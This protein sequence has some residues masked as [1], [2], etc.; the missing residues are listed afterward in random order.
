M[1][2]NRVLTAVSGV[3]AVAGVLASLPV[4]ANAAAYYTYYPTAVSINGSVLS[5]PGH[6][7]EKDPFGGAKAAVTSF[8]PIW[9]IDEALGKLNVKVSWDGVNGVLNFTTPSGMT[10]NYPSTPKAVAINSGTMEIQIN[11]KVV[12][13][14]PRISY[15]DS[16]TV[17]LTTF[18]PVYYLEKALGYMGVTTG[19]NGT[20]WTMQY[21]STTVTPPTNTGE[22]VKAAAAVAF[23]KAMGI[24]PDASSP[25]PY[26]DVSQ[27]DWEWIAPLVNSNYVYVVKGVSVP[28]GTSVFT[29]SSSTTFGSDVTES[30]IDRAFQVASGWKTGHDSFLPGGSVENFAGICGVNNG[31]PSSGNLTLSDVSIMAANLTRIEKGYIALGNNQYQLVYRPQDPGNYWETSIPAATYA[32]NKAEGI[33][34]INQVVVT[35][36]G[37]NNFET[38]APDLSD[39]N[40]VFITGV[41]TP[42]QYSLDNGQTWHTASGRNGFDSSDPSNGGMSNPST[43]LIKDT[44]GGGGI[45]VYAKVNGAYQ[46]AAIGGI[47]NQNGSLVPNYQ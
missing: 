17:N 5:T 12:T 13:Y 19:W 4:T 43:V 45:C 11:G 24:Q 34:L 3:L 29:P 14:A 31:L 8:L 26:S 25:D 30:D 16:G 1:T 28:M 37:G 33:K 38:K 36:E 42:E 21:G 6:I 7:A 27:S 35:Y 20:D 9:Y 32:A 46:T 47:N 44:T 23:A 15:Y 10:V 2:R 41:N 39:S 18:I 40:P 22:T